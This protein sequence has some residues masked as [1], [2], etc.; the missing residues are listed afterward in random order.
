M[1]IFDAWQEAKQECYRWLD[2]QRVHMTAL[3]YRSLWEEERAMTGPDPY[4]WG[5]KKTRAE[6]DKMLD[7]ALCQGLVSRRFQPEDMFHPS[8]LET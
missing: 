4:V 5:F 6:V 2:R 1:S 3:W 8:T 7:Y